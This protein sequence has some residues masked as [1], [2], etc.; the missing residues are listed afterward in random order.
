[1]RSYQFWDKEFLINANIIFEKK[2]K[3]RQKRKNPSYKYHI[4]LTQK[5]S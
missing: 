2:K 5:F 1:M 3:K 4:A